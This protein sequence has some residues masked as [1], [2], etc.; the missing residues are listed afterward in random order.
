[1]IAKSVFI[2]PSG[3][4]YLATIP[5]WHLKQHIS[6]KTVLNLY[7]AAIFPREAFVDHLTSDPLP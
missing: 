6:N 4:L 3:H 2:P 7:T 1:M 5:K